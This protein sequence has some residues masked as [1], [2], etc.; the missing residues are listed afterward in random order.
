MKTGFRIAALSAVAAVLLAVSATGQVTTNSLPAGFTAADFA[1]L[2]FSPE[3][4]VLG[5]DNFNNTIFTAGVSY[6]VATAA[7]APGD[8]FYWYRVNAK[9]FVL[10]ADSIGRITV[11]LNT[12][13]IKTVGPVL[14]FGQY[15]NNGV[16]PLS[17]VA[18]GVTPLKISWDATPNGDGLFAGETS[19]LWVV[20]TWPPAARVSMQIIDG[21][22]ATAHV[23]APIPEPLSMTMA[24]LGLAAIAALRRKA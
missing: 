3:Q 13:L 12:A 16:G 20:S 5:L 10:P 11:N 8:Y 1:A 24:G 21:G 9:N 15:E 4:V 23:P 17:L 19:Y 14:Q 18:Q 22:V 6:A 2:M 7:G